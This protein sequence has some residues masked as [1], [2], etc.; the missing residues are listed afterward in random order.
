MRLAERQEQHVAGAIRTIP[1][2]LG[3]ESEQE[4]RVSEMVPQHP[5]LP[6]SGVP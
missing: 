3:L 6:A 1:T 5:R 2:D 4:A